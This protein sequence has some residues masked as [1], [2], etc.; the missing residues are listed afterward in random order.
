MKKIIAFLIAAFALTACSEEIPQFILD[1]Y[2]LTPD[3]NFDVNDMKNLNTPPVSVAVGKKE[4]KQQYR[5]NFTD[6]EA[7]TF[8]NDFELPCQNRRS[9]YWIPDT[10]YVKDNVL[11]VT[12]QAKTGA[13]IRSLLEKNLG[14]DWNK[15]VRDPKDG[16]GQNKS[17]ADSEYWGITGAALKKQGDIYG[18]YVARI[19]M[20][21]KA[22][23][24]WMAYWFYGNDNSAEGRKLGRDYEFD[25]LEYHQI[26]TNSKKVAT[27]THWPI[28]LPGTSKRT[29][30]TYDTELSS[31]V[32]DWHT[33]ALLWTPDAVVYYIDWRPVSYILADGRWKNTALS[34][35]KISQLKKTH[36]MISPVPLEVHFSNEVGGTDWMTLWAGALD[37]DQLKKEPDNMMVDWYVH[38]TTDDLKKEAKAAGVTYGEY[39]N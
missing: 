5:L 13:E 15:T 30:A 34:Q 37:V 28:E 36:E 32:A 12:T 2:K 8:K 17:I 6:A 18:L 20:K 3:K 9:S 21:R 29:S 14:A 22:T 1:S 39:L 24:H 11:N 27:T 38:Y 16:G 35:A 19:A 23:G 26:N 25:M 7:E 4:F 10:V 31:S 33:Y